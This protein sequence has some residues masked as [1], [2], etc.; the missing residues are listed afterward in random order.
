MDWT[1]RVQ[2]RHRDEAIAYARGHELRIGRPVH[3]DEDYDR[4]S[5]L[6][7][8]LAALG[9]DIANGLRAEA[10]RARLDVDRIEALVKCELENP[11]AALG[12]IGEEGTPAIAR[13]E[14]RLYAE[15]FDDE[16]A[17]QAALHRHLQRS[18][19]ASTFSKLGVLHVRLEIAV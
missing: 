19:L 12:V 7:H 16:A 5:A 15:T 18:P 2:S 1:V 14:V 10:Q 13:V 4:L 17:V 3:F 9:G 6:E 8:T 11:N